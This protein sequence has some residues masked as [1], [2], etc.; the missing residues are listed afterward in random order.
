MKVPTPAVAI[1]C[2]RDSLKST[3][4]NNENLGFLILFVPSS[5]ISAK[6]ISFVVIAK[7]LYNALYF[8]SGK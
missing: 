2:N 4:T 1:Y 6:I 3:S 5:P 8:S 7:V